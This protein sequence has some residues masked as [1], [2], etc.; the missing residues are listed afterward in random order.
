MEREQVA[1]LTAELRA[2]MRLFERVYQRL[3]NRLELGLDTPA[4]LESGQPIEGIR[5]QLLSEKTFDVM[6]R[7]RGF[8]HFVR[9][10]YGAE[11]E[12]NQLTTNLNLALRLLEL[13]SK[14]VQYFLEQ[15]SQ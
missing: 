5:P 7:L 3:Q 6:N 1:G 9:H 12:I 11:I 15:L 8:R 4:Q 13:L 10:A 14:D 2:Q